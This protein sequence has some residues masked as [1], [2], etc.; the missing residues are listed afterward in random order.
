VGSRLETAV[1]DERFIDVLSV[2]TQVTVE[3]RRR[4]ERVTR[5]MLHAA[6]LPAGSDMKRL[7][8]QIGGVDR[9]LRSLERRLDALKPAEPGPTPLEPKRRANARQRQSR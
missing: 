6:N 5:R 3:M 2:A 1:Q 4:A 8:E 9:R 7:S